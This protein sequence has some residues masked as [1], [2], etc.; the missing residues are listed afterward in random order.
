MIKKWF[1]IITDQRITM[2]ERMFRMVTCICMIA[3]A[4]TMPMG[5]NIWNILLLIIA[6][7]I[8]ALVVR[9]SIRKGDVRPMRPD[10]S[11]DHHGF[12][13]PAVSFRLFLGGRLLQRG[14]GVVRTLFYLCL[15]YFAGTAD[16]VFFFF[17]HGGDSAVLRPC[18]LCTEIGC[19]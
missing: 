19:T 17:M 3:V 9:L 4:F 14:A 12:A 1:D 8:M 10:G 2:R 7:V 15:R 6:L 5:R 11:H 18:F 13:A 16:G